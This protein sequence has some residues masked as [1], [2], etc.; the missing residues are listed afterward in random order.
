LRRNSRPQALARKGQLQQCDGAAIP[1]SGWQPVVPSRLRHGRRAGRSLGSHPLDYF[2]ENEPR[3]AT[4]SYGSRE[5][6]IVPDQLPYCGRA[7]AEKLR[8][9]TDGDEDSWKEFR[10]LAHAAPHIRK[11]LT[12]T[13][14]VLR[15]LL[16]R[17]SGQRWSP[18]LV[19]Q[20]RPLRHWGKYAIG[21]RHEQLSISLVFHQILP[22]TGRQDCLWE[23]APGRPLASLF[24]GHP[25]R[26]MTRHAS[27]SRLAKTPLQRGK[28]FCAC[29]VQWARAERYWPITSS[30]SS[31]RTS[32]I[33]TCHHRCRTDRCGGTP[34][35]NSV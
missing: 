33:R 25:C 2:F 18:P 23:A 30:S 34:R 27:T 9:F 1:S 4:D 7:H 14:S 6:R 32:S 20:R 24:A 19:S 13:Q 5:A 17:P 26:L 3:C 22:A 11:D 29:S 10:K 21:F 35:R 31:F 12:W 8:G 16:T 28:P 15:G